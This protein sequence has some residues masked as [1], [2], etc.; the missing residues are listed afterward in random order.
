MKRRH[1]L[2][3][4]K[5]ALTAYLMLLPDTIGLAIFI[6]V[7]M[8]FAVYTSFHSWNGIEPMKFIG[9]ANY[10][11]LIGDVDFWTSLVVTLKYSIVYIPAVYCVSLGL[12]L[13]INKLRGKF[14][15]FTRMAF[16]LP[17]SISTVVA[18]LLWMFMYDPKSG[19]F[20]V[21]LS[22]LGIPKQ[23]FL[24]SSSQA[25]LSVVV[26]SVWLIVGYNM[27]IFLAALKEVP[28][29]YYEAAD[30]DGASAVQKFLHITL[31]SI[32][33]TSLFILVV[34][35]IGS[36]QVFDQIKV[37]TNGG[38]AKATEVTVFHIYNQAF[39]LFD[40]GYSSTMAVALLVII[41]ILSLFQFKLLGRKE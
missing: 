26:V 6:F 5:E 40:F 27:I 7:P 22:K 10:K 28:L 18:G 11:R 23:Q 4:S 25:L 9:L 12:A 8:L 39:T 14:E 38:P 36:F 41:M 3:R 30:L 29:D 15:L 33:N 34:T 17:Y 32:K 37:M 31:P 20:N 19:Y 2:G 16:F 35:T 13:L 21:I 24:A 1:L